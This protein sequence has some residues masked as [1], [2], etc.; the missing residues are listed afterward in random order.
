MLL[1]CMSID[2]NNRLLI[3]NCDVAALAEKFGTPLYILSENQIRRNCRKFMSSLKEYFD[4]N[5]KILYAS[6][7]LSCKSLYKIIDEE[8]FGADVVSGGELYTALAANFPPEKIY[9][10]GNNKTR[11]EIKMALKENIGRIVVDNLDELYTIDEIARNLGK[12]A[13]VSFRVKPGVEAHTHEFIKTGA[14]DSKFGLALDGGEAENAIKIAKN[15]QNIEVCGV[16]S[17]I[18]SQIFETDAFVLAAE[19]MVNFMADLRENDG[20]LI[21]E[22]NLGGGFGIKYTDKDAPLPIEKYFE[23]ISSKIKETCSTRSFPVPSIV[24]EPGRS[25]VGDAGITVYEIGSIKEIPGVRTYISVDGGMTDNPRYIMYGAEYEAI[26][27]DNPTAERTKKVTIVGKCCESGDVLIRDIFMSKMRRGGHL[28]V[29]STGAYN[30]SMASNYNR[31]ARPPIVLVNG[32]NA[33]VIVRRESYEDLIR[34][35]L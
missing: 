2:E 1:D 19:K 34:N 35:D 26:Y 21:S 6:K 9:F 4:G 25:I 5:G 10:H 18:G 33:R 32:A 8:N 22:L 16:H 11:A 3:E 14:I 12:V 7:A 23:K 24:F 30:Y 20:I 29:L 13:S 28:A 15:L 27:V 17:H 31:V